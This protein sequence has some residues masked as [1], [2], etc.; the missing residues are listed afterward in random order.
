MNMDVTTNITDT[1]LV[2]EGGGMRASYT[3][4][5]VC[6]LLEAGLYFDFVTGISAGSSNTVNYIARS[7]LRARQS[8]VDFADDPRFGSWKTWIRGQGMFNAHYIYQETCRPDGQLPFDFDT[9]WANPTRFSIGA[10]DMDAGRT[11]YKTRADIHTDDDL[12]AWVRASST[13]P[14]V[15]PPIT[16]DGRTYVDG[17]LGHGGGIPL[18]AAQET[19][20][21]RFF[22]VLTRPRDYIKPPSKHSHFFH[23]YYRKH[24]AVAEGILGRPHEYNTTR[25]ELLDLE[26]SGQAYLFFPEHMTVSNQTRDVAQL[27]ASY[28]AGLAQS[29]MELPRWRDFL[30]M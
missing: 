1:A 23:A 30:G 29:Q 26:S 4:A 5:V 10:F 2:F 6:A 25:E 22:V 11:V 19:G 24:P 12:M 16:I 20:F 27:R 9:F 21:K 17:A 3:A 18:A 7:P 28:E 8:F 13:M 14:L 15:M